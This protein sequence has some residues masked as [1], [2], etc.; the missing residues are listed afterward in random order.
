MEVKQLYTQCLAEAAYYVESEGEAI[1]IDPIREIGEYLDLIKD[2]NV[3]LKYVFETHFHA[4]FVSGHIDLARATGAEI[5]YGPGAKTGYKIYNAADEEEFKIG[6]VII[7]ALH[8]PGH[9]LESTSYLLI[10]EEGKENAIFTGDTVF[11]GDVGRP[12]LL[13]GT[14]T[15]DELAGMMYDTIRNKIMPLADNIILYPGHGPGSQCGKNLGDATWSTIGE[16]KQTNYAFQS[17]S[18]KE[19]VDKLTA[20]LTAPP[21]YFFKD[22]EINK[23]GYTSL[24]DVVEKN[25]HSVSLDEFQDI[26]RNGGLVLDTRNQEDFEKGFITGSLNVGLNG[27][28]AIWVGTLVDIETPLLLITDEGK[29]EESIVRLARVGYENVAGYLEGGISTWK[30]ANLSMITIQSVEAEELGGRLGETKVL[31]VRK[32]SEFENGHVKK[33]IN[34]PLSELQDRMHE[35][36]KDTDYVVHCKSGYR[37]M[38][39]SSILKANGFDFLYN[40]NGGY[41]SIRKANI[42]VVLPATT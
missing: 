8:T 2:R 14:A 42:P 12:D 9:T 34:I 22:A 24:D 41:L 33:A 13:D 3:K 27:Q 36:D 6:K 38:I 29:E 20:N 15:S 35:L 23:N 4:D 30:N 25:L 10:D 37:S 1:I 7:K 28:Y 40:V 32:V 16:Q 39:A 21:R 31:D 19:F 11:V 17:M 18:K 26:I 5:V